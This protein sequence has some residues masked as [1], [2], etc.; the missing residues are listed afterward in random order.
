MFNT[1]FGAF[2][3]SAWEAMCQQVF[4]RKY[5]A[6]DYQ[7]MPASPGDFGLEGFTL[8]TGWGFQCYCPDKHYDRGELY[9]KQRDKIT[10][11]LEKLKTYKEEIA[12]RLGSTKLNH[13]VFVTPE[14]DKN[15]LL[16]HARTKERQV[17]AWGLPFISDDFTVLLYDGDNYLVEINEI[18]SAAG[19]A[20]VFDDVAPLLAQLSGPPEEYE[21]NIRRKSQKRLADA[22]GSENFDRRVHSLH[23]LTLE[24]FLA[25]DGYFRR[26]ESSAPVVYVRLVRLINEFENYVAETSTTWMGT[27]EALTSQVK[28]NLEQRIVRDLAPKF[29]ATNASKI[30]RL[31]VARWLAI[32]EL[33]YE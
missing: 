32:C 13:W 9:E 12:R 26:I 33:D 1:K 15:A 31:M 24:N 11:D 5:Q 6:D 22:R 8:R 30:A 25:A 21:G 29:D 7:V 20:L 27:P 23:Q 3:G 14:F 10:A 17:R 16:A 18:L 19:E 2:N 28:E 4:K